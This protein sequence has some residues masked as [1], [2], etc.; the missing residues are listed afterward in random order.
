[1]N[2][3]IY[4][5]I[6]T[7]IHSRQLT[8]AKVLWALLA[9]YVGSEHCIHQCHG[10]EDAEGIEHRKHAETVCVLV[11]WCVYLCVCVYVCACVCVYVYVYVCV[12]A[13][14][15]ERERASVCICVY[16]CE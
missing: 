12:C 7:F 8:V 6:N 15:R 1:M 13:R 9:K 11:S 16:L 14:E 10:K 3:Y 5:Y 2:M 4:I